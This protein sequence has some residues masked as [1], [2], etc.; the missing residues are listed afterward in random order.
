[1]LL[2]LL[3]FPLSNK[4]H[5][6]TPDLQTI[7]LPND[8]RKNWKQGKQNPKKTHFAIQ[9]KMRAKR[10]SAHFLFGP[11]KKWRLQESHRN[12]F[13]KLILTVRLSMPSLY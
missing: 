5:T 2:L 11:P 9:L 12:D 10:Y 1:M 8:H 4:T 3:D 13:K 6:H 7:L